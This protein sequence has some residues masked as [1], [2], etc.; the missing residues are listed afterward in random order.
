MTHYFMIK[1]IEDGR[2]NAKLNN[3]KF[4]FESI[5]VVMEDSKLDCSVIYQENRQISK[6]ES[7][8][9]KENIKGVINKKVLNRLNKNIDQQLIPF[10]DAFRIFFVDVEIDDVVDPTLAHPSK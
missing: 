4:I 10:T 3:P 6:F 8:I 7:T 5:V 1:R 9:S 2:Y